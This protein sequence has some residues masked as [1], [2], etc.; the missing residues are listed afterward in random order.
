[1]NSP[2][3]TQDE[4]AFTSDEE[5]KHWQYAWHILDAGTTKV[6]A[7]DLCTVECVRFYDARIFSSSFLPSDKTVSRT[8][9]KVIS[10]ES[11]EYNQCKMQ[12]RDQQQHLSQHKV[13]IVGAKGF[14]TLPSP[15]PCK[16]ISKKPTVENFKELKKMI[17]SKMLKKAKSSKAVSSKVTLCLIRYF[18]LS[19]YVVVECSWICWF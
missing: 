8:S 5:K 12:H 7:N 6:G 11:N 2:N 10:V 9:Y 4:Y 19:L 3:N 13:D 14:F 18:L 16:L 17:K 15:D 1:V